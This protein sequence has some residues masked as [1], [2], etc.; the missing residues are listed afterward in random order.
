[1]TDLT[2]R[3]ASVEDI[4]AVG[5][6]VVDA[7]S[8]LRTLRGG[9]DLLASLGMPADIP[10]EALAGAMCGGAVLDATTLVAVL[11]GAVVGYV[12]VVRTGEGV[13]LMG[14]H[15]QR[16]MRRRRIGTTLLAEAR[17]LAAAQ[18]TR[19]E[20]IALPGDQTIKSLLESAGFKARQLRM[21]A[22]R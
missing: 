10:A 12:I 1:V 9:P 17:A 4:G 3:P 7:L 19:F 6:L 13:D 11:E 15:T 20:A 22:D 14:V 16:S 8:Q 5:G 18:G 2:V 21:S